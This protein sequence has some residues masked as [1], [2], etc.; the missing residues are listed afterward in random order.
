MH[1]RQGAKG[2]KDGGAGTHM[3]TSTHTLTRTHTHA[4]THP[5]PHTCT[6]TQVHAPGRGCSVGRG[7]CTERSSGCHRSGS[8]GGARVGRAALLSLL[9]NHDA[10]QQHGDDTHGG[11]DVVGHALNLRAYAG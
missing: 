9:A 8:H 7:G 5:H 1:T 10:T 4:H 6:N 3:R 11:E 2:Q